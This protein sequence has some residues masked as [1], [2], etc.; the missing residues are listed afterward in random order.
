MRS[1]FP[2][3]LLSAFAMLGSSGPA[4]ALPADQVTAKLDTI[5]VFAPI[6]PQSPTAPRP[7]VYKLDGSSRD[8]YFAAFSP[9]AIQ[10]L[11]SKRI[12]EQNPELAKTVRFAPFSL[13]KFDT[14]VQG[15][16]SKNSNARVIYVPD[17][18]QLSIVEQLLKKQGVKEADAK[19][20]ATTVPIVFCPQPS[21]L[22]TPQAGP[23]KGKSF[24]PCSTDFNALKAMVDKGLSSNSD[25][26]KSGV[27]VVAIPLPSFINLISKGTAD[28][29]GNFRV[30]PSPSSVKAIQE[31]QKKASTPSKK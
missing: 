20:A 7:L 3:L 31:L 16:L 28:Q 6:D 27:N 14:E 15:I 11:L 4:L 23:L 10:Q 17:P 5:L 25:L 29:V 26:K 24:V 12:A 18:D 21:I 8:V 2:S 1:V 9:S 30:L 13:A 22:A 19:A